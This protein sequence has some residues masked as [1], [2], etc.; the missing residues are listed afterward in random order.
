VALV[1]RSILNADTSGENIPG[2]PS[3]SLNAVPCSSIV[4]DR[5]SLRADGLA[6]PGSR[7]ETAGNALDV[8]SAALS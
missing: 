1:D 6:F 8:S 3:P 5:S 4:S 7:T 2:N